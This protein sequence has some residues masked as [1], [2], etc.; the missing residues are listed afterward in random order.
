[1][2]SG[3][4]RRR[5]AAD[6]RWSLGGSERR[7]E[8]VRRPRSSASSASVEAGDVAAGHARSRRSPLRRRRQRSPPPTRW[9]SRRRR[10]TVFRTRRRRPSGRRGRGSAATISPGCSAVSNMP[11][12][13]RAR[14]E[15]RVA[16]RRHELDDGVGSDQ[17]DRV[18]GGRIGE[19]DRPA[20]RAPG[21]HRRIGDDARRLREQRRPGAPTRSSSRQLGVRGH[22]ADA[23]AA[24]GSARRREAR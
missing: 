7:G 6:A 20:D 9:R 18:V 8:S 10:A 17:R 12:K 16:R 24:V 23:Q 22:R 15:R 14:S 19:R 4:T 3:A 2:S 1:M 5:Y 21:A 13:N 11:R